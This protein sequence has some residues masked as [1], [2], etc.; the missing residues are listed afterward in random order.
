MNPTTKDRVPRKS[1]SRFRPVLIC[2]LVATLQIAPHLVSAPAEAH[3]VSCS[4]TAYTPER[5]AWGKSWNVWAGGKIQCSGF[6][7]VL[8]V[9]VCLQRHQI[10]GWWVTEA[11]LTAGQ[12]N[13]AFVATEFQTWCDPEL[14]ERTWRTVADGT[15]THHGTNTNQHVSSHNRFSCNAPPPPDPRDPVSILAYIP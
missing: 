11:C 5:R 10:G 12:S 3:S 14:G 1:R 15:W 6:A 7:D 4:A 2:L 13:A 9:R 8:S